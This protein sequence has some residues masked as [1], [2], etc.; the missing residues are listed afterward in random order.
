[1]FLGWKFDSSL[2]GPFTLFEETSHSSAIVSH[3]EYGLL[4]N[5]AAVECTY[6]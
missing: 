5:E 6:R 1:M 3:V 4:V 2:L